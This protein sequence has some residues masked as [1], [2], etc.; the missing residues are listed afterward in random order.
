[1]KFIKKKKQERIE[2]IRKYYKDKNNNLERKLNLN[3]E[4]YNYF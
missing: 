4:K 2:E 3:L 1:M